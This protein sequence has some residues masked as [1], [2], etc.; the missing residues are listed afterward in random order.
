MD[1][2]VAFHSSIT[3]FLLSCLPRPTLDANFTWANTG[4]TVF[5][6][7]PATQ[8]EADQPGSD[9]EEAAS[10]ADIHFEPI[11]S[12]PEVETK[13][14]DEDEEILFKER[15]KLFR[16]DRNL[17]QWK[18]RGVG[19]I[20]ILYHPQ[21]R[22][23]RVLM[24]RDQVLKVCANHTITQGMEL[25]PMN[26]SNNALVWNAT[27]YAEGS[28]QIEQLAAKFKTAELADSF[29][30][31]F[32]ECLSRLSQADCGQMSRA[33]EHSREGNPTVF[34]CVSADGEPLGKITMELF[35]HIV[36][37]TAENFRALCTGE[38]GFGFRNSVF[39]RIIPDFM[40]QV[41]P[42]PWGGDVTNQDGTGG[43]SIYGETFED[44]NFDVRHTDA[45]LLSMAN[46]GRDTNNS[47]FFIT[48]KKGEHLDFK[49]VAFGFVKDGMDVVK[50]MGELGTKSGK[51]SKKIVITDCGQLQ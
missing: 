47:Q 51:P 11:V 41:C 35:S 44:E 46:R 30:K 10:S 28:A 20:K 22:C 45:G 34:F 21:K 33:Q 38:R 18:E 8:T 43:K 42:A 48:L 23:Y 32:E 40:C 16:W 49:H 26:T 3:L 14:G 9:E 12:L 27:D 17:N 31:T 39:H 15:A 7:A 6:A 2:R 5:G 1:C 37:K 19:D 29:R 24:R 50:Q 25:V 4:T 13:S 36:P